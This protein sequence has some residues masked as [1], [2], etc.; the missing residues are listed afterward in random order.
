[1]K[2]L[3]L[4]FRLRE[5]VLYH[6]LLRAYFPIHWQLTLSPRF[7]PEGIESRRFE[8]TAFR[9]AVACFTDCAYFLRISF[10][11]ISAEWYIIAFL[12]SFA[13]VLHSTVLLLFQVVLVDY[14]FD[15][16]PF[17]AQFESWEV[18]LLFYFFVWSIYVNFAQILQEW[19]EEILSVGSYSLC[20]FHFLG[21]CVRSA[22]S[23][24]CIIW[25]WLSMLSLTYRGVLVFFL[26]AR[27]F[28]AN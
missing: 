3:S 17:N 28:V 16:G 26:V 10:L 13:Q 8:P 24:F 1:M 7:W 6:S 22:A 15:C 25:K 23:D 21:S 2:F 12:I 18:G 4:F 27:F 14:Q 11:K 5:K 19:I 20:L 9:T